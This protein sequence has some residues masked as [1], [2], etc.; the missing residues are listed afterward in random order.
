MKTWTSMPLF[1]T[2]VGERLKDEGITAAVENN[3]VLVA[4]MRELAKH[5]ARSRFDR[6]VDMDMLYIDEP[7]TRKLKTMGNSRGGI[8]RGREW[9]YA[10]YTKSERA[11]SHGNRLTR[12]RLK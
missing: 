5:I 1:D 12:W 11:E 4:E 10:G 7:T 8:F 6:V 9:E 2:A 3:A